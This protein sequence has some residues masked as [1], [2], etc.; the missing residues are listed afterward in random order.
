MLGSFDCDP[1]MTDREVLKW[2][3]DG[4]IM[5]PEV[6]PAEVNERVMDYA[7]THPGNPGLD[8]L[9]A[10][11]YVKSVVLNPLLAGIVRSLLGRN[12][13]SPS[14][15]ANHQSAGPQAGMPWHQDG[16]A[17][18][19][20]A[21]DCLQ[22]FY[23][24]Q[25]VT[26]EM[27]PTLILPGSQFLFQRNQYMT[28]YG[29][30]RGEV[31][32]AAAGGSIFITH[33][34]IW[35]RRPPSRSTNTRNLFKFWYIRTVSPAWDWVRESGFDMDDTF[36]CTE[37]GNLLGRDDRRARN[38]AAEAF[39]WLAGLHE[40]FTTMVLHHNLPIYFPPA[41]QPMEPSGAQEKAI[42]RH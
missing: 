16:G 4:Y 20:P 6:V 12:F 15:A 8:L 35:H 34:G 32:T 11:W 13:T 19:G 33:Y 41:A 2:C 17:V 37:T 39:H 29:S 21:L 3:R 7:K 42:Q 26:P 5:L 40:A 14:F 25:A 24:P 31:S 10:D 36:R 27:G 28:H 23:L 38:D 30:I 1:T 18:Y 22:V 9:D